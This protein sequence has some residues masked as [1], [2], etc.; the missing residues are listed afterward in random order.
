MY[1]LLLEELSDIKSKT[2]HKRKTT[3]GTDNNGTFV[4]T[5]N[6]MKES[7]NRRKERTTWD[8]QQCSKTTMTSQKNDVE[9]DGIPRNRS[10]VKHRV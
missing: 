7:Q 10:K 5:M 6:R 9:R 4:N 3:R 1:A 2:N 8:A